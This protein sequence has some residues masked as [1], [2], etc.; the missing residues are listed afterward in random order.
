[1]FL[2]SSIMNF[3]CVP[4]GIDL[5]E[6]IDDEAD[7]GEGDTTETGEPT[8]DTGTDTGGDG[9]W[10]EIRCVDLSPSVACLGRLPGADDTWV[11]V[12]KVCTILSLVGEEVEAWGPGSCAEGLKPELGSWDSVRC[13]THETIGTACFGF[14]GDYGTALVE[15]CTFDLADT[16]PPWPAG[17]CV[18]SNPSTGAHPFDDAWCFQGANGS[19]YANIGGGLAL[20]EPTCWLDERMPAEPPSCEPLP[21]GDPWGPCP[22]DGTTGL[23]TLCDEGVACVPS[24]FGNMCLPVGECDDPGFGDGYSM[25]WGNVCYA[26][27]MYD[28]DCGP[29]M[30]CDVSLNDE[31]MCAWPLG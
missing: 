23:P 7:M 9:G 11:F 28:D 17:A 14:L 21:I 3:A 24:Q 20:I 13:F 16:A 4:G 1:M 26:R 8:D 22:T 12:S 5:D 29:G 10:A 15:P 30:I 6:G 18:N 2:A 27:C 25:G 31:P 19:C